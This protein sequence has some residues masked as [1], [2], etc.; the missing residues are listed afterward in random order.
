M[1]VHQAQLGWR[2]RRGMKELDYLLL[3]HLDHCRT[4][5]ESSG[6][7]ELVLFQRLLDESDDTL[8]RY[9]YRALIPGDPAL[10]ALVDRILSAAASHP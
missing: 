8:W 7:A 6:A 4:L 1:A 5:P 2:C 3:A 9:F 10:A